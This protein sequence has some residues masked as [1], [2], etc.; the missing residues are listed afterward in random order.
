VYDGV[1][2]P[3]FLPVFAAATG[4]DRLDYVVLLPTVERCVQRVRTRTGHGF[5]D[6]AATRKM[7]HEFATAPVDD[8]HVLADPPGGPDVVA[9]LVEAALAAGTLAYTPSPG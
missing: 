3:W 1:V 5:G 4:L 2:G 7:H 8:R 9:D 6:E